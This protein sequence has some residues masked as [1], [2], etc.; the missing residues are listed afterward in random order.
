MGFFMLSNQFGPSTGYTGASFDGN[1]SCNSCHSTGSYGTTNTIQLLSGGTPV[2]TYL[3]GASYVVRVNIGGSSPAM[4]FQLT[5]AFQG[6]NNNINNWG[7]LP[8][9]TTNASL[10]GRNYIQHTSPMASAAFVDIPWTAPSSTTTVVF[11]SGVNRVNSNGQQ[12]GDH[13]SSA[14]LTVNSGCATITVGPGTLPG[15]T[16][17]TAYSQTITQSG[18]TGTP[19]WS[20]STGTLP[21]GLSLN[22]STG[23]ITGTPTTAGTYTFTITVTGG[24]GCTGSQSYSV[25]IGCP[26]VTVN[27]T[28]PNATVGSTYNQTLT[29]TGGT[30]TYTWSVSTGSLP[31]G[32]SLNTTTGA[33]T[34]TPTTTGSYTFTITATGNGTCTGSQS[35]TVVITCPTVTVS[36]GTIPT[37]V[38]GTA[39][40]QTYTQT[41]G[42]GTIVWSAT[43]LPPGVT[44][45]SSTGLLSG[46]PTTTG[47][48]NIVITA[49]GN[50]PCSGTQTFS[51]T[52][53]TCPAVTVSPGTIPTMTVGTAVN[54]TYTQTGLSGTVT[55]S[56]TGLPPGV[57]INSTTG[58][59]SGTPTTT[60]TYNI[61][62]TAT[63]NGPCSGTQTF[64]NTVVSCP[65]IT[66]T[67]ATLATI[68]VGTFFSQTFAQSGGTGT[69]TW[70]SSG[71]LPPGLNLTGNVLSGTPTVSGTY[72]FTITASGNGPC[73]GS[74][75][76]TVTV[77]CPTITI[78]PVSL[79]AMTV[80]SVF[81]QTF[82]QTGGT[83]T[84]T[85]SFTG[86]LPPGLSLNTTTGAL[87]G[88]PT[89]AGTYTFTIVGTN[90]AQNCSGSRTYTVTVS[91]PTITV[92]PNTLPN[93]PIGQAYS[94][95]VTQTGGTGT[96]TWSVSSGTLPTG[97]TLNSTSGVI[98]GT[99]TVA[100]SYT[101]TIT[102]TDAF[103]CTGIHNYTIVVACPTISLNPGT[104]PPGN[105]GFAY[106][107]T[108]T[109]T[110]STNSFTFAVS[111]GT[112]P[113]GVTLNTTSG[114][115]SGTA[116][117]AGTYTFT[118][119]ATDTYGC[120]TS[121]TYTVTI[122]P[123]TP[124]VVNPAT[125]PDGT[126]NTAYSQTATQTGG[127]GTITWS[128]SGT[129]PPGITINSSTGVLS[130]TP[131]T[132][133]TYTF[134]IIATD[135]IGCSGTH[136]YTIDI[137][138]PTIT[139]APATLPDGTVNTAYSQTATQ[140]GSTGT[141]TWST[142]GTLPPG[143]SINS[144]SG[145][146]SGT[147]TATGTFTFTITATDGFGCTGSQSY[148]I[149]INCPT[150][151][152]SPG[153]LPADTVGE[154][155]NQTITQTGST[156]TTLTYTVSS[157]T[158]PPGMTLNATTGVISGTTTASGTATFDITVT[159]EFGCSS[160]VT[161]TINSNCPVIV[162]NETSLPTIFANTPYSQTLTLTGGTSPYTYT[163][164]SGTLPTGI[165]LDANTGVVSGT[166][167]D[168]GSFTITVTV[169][170]ANGCTGTQTFT[171][172]VDWPVSVKNVVAGKESVA[173][174]PNIV[175]DKTMAHVI[176]NFSGKAQI[177]VLDITG[178]IVYSN[179]ANLQM[180]ENRINLDLHELS[181]GSYTFH[182]KPLNV[183]PV[184]FTKQ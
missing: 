71:T 175:T 166:S 161:Y 145:V 126:V 12:T 81:S 173:L 152:L 7:T 116:S 16:A 46:T 57:T 94:Q 99:P 49:T 11:Y 41:G 182:I 120:T 74:Q 131:T 28:L 38:V 181:S 68:T 177:R 6:S 31:P 117:T 60:G 33:V 25:V 75:T 101:F 55:W 178:K 118:I 9:G 23:A 54:Q 21:T 102:A 123:C 10:G 32:L 140:T 143:L 72:T 107:Q 18:A 132:T 110:G 97:V 134:T 73:S 78:N 29:Q 40:N 176:S 159:D 151:T 34:G 80:G 114:V 36:P 98:S 157:G 148:T 63:G 96:I 156:G 127:T 62:I 69:I 82:T 163:V 141:I 150:I 154:G 56:A 4:G 139:I 170:D 130:G 171:I 168:I 45:N 135:G 162:I 88:T 20:V 14:S 87:T 124:L 103:G 153:T 138:C 184:K 183:A 3:P 44:I 58:L 84:F 164:T 64:N 53:V 144:T 179:V 108:I 122:S 155:Y 52:V 174:L 61:V 106:N 125:L 39:V 93:A 50:G 83:G 136:T 85:W 92:S 147:P 172:V 30:G 79:P 146:L 165:T 15:G 66:V 160:T 133:G 105:V 109:V 65:T 158:L 43:G 37:M 35:Y 86:T 115:L 26:T 24:N 119:T 95:T 91:C 112:L 104:L 76:Y 67:P 13:A 47:T 8:G 27:G 77:G 1:T 149:D 128:T 22:T 113:P 137:N 111:S 2:T 70:S 5:S 42:S 51:N 142:S 48:Y 180:G 121:T 90:T 100:G 167:T 89:T 19:A 169:T 17:G 59:L 129:L